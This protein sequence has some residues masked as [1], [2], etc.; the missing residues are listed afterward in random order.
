MAGYDIRTA[1]MA[2]C[3]LVMVDAAVSGVAYSTDPSAGLATGLSTDPA[4]GADNMIINSAWGL[5]K[6]IVEGQVDADLYVVRK[7][8]TPLLA[9]KKIGNKTYMVAR[10]TDG[11]TDSVKVPAEMTKKSSL[12]DEQVLDIAGQVLLIEKYFRKPVD[13][14]WAIDRNGTVFILQARP[15]RVIAKNEIS[16]TGRP[17]GPAGLKPLNVLLKNKGPIVQ[18]G[19]GAGRVFVLKRME[20]LDNFPKGAILVARNDSSEFIRAIP[21]ASAIITDVGT[22]TSHMSSLCRE[23]RVPAIVNAGDATKISEA[24]AGNNSSNRG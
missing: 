17:K 15:L 8:S 7:Q 18:K 9:D 13:V 1:R 11:G 23:F 19:F 2:V 22:P 24:R 6:S 4:M 10:R 20:D 3:C 14:E 5:G 16:L 12:T 21:Y